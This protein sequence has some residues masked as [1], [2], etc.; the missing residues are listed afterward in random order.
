MNQEVANIFNPTAPQANFDE[1]RIALASPEKILSWSYRRD[2]EAGDH[3]L[4][5]LQTGA[6]R[7]LLRAYLRSGEG[8]RMPVRQV[9]AYE[10]SRGSPARNAAS[11]S[12]F[13]KV[14]RERMGHIELASPVA[15]IW[16]LKSLPSA[17]RPDARYHAAR[18][19]TRSSISSNTSSS[20]PGMTELSHGPA[21][22]RGG[23]S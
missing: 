7:P 10:V 18:S 22:D 6:R 4:P 13:Q 20:N 9:Q 12:R 23:V 3:Q 8:L 14:R 11:K 15:H 21:S 17:H 5:D 1:I 16:F 19:R 2:Q